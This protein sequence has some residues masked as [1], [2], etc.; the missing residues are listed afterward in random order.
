MSYYTLPSFN[1]NNISINNNE[2]LTIS[3]SLVQYVEQ[4]YNNLIENQYN[5]FGLRFVYIYPLL[6]KKLKQYID[7]FFYNIIEINTICSLINDN[8]K[9]LLIDNNE[10]KDNLINYTNIFDSFNTYLYKNEIV[11]NLKY[12]LILKNNIIKNLKDF[13]EILTLIKDYQEYR[14][15]IIIKIKNTNEN[16]YINII[17]ILSVIYNKIVVLKPNSGNI[18]TFER[19][20]VCKKYNKSIH[21]DSL[22]RDIKRENSVSV[23]NIPL[24]FLNKLD[25]CNNIMGQQQLD[26]IL[27]MHQCNYNKDKH[28]KI[29]NLYKKINHKVINW[30]ESNNI[31]KIKNNERTYSIDSNM[32]INNNSEES[33]D[34]MLYIDED[35]EEDDEE[36]EEDEEIGTVVNSIINELEK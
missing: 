24:F 15:D 11:D 9:I 17:Y 14:G 32:E 26:C 5:E 7:I 1:T 16:M 23:S 21:L 20:I 3:N 4:C 30:L 2:D 22:I 28:D 12:S 18:F 25:E 35:D 33:N 34:E 31:K 27:F 8:S 19:Y 36:N 29:E 10:M 6:N 13:I